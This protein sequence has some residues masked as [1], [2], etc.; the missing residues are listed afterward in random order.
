[1]VLYSPLEE[2]NT[3][4]GINSNVLKYNNIP[5]TENS[6]RKEWGYNCRITHNSNPIF[7]YGYINTYKNSLNFTKNSFFI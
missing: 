5:I 6:I 3:I 2:D 4:Y 7:C 1:M